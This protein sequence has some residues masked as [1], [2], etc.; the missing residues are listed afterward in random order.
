MKKFT[1][2]FLALILC[3]G[4]ATTAFAAEEETPFELT[5]TDGIDTTVWAENETLEYC[6]TDNGLD[7]DNLPYIVDTYTGVNHTPV[8]QFFTVTNTHQNNENDVEWGEAGANKGY[9]YFKKF[10]LQP[11]G[12]MKNVEVTIEDYGWTVEEQDVG[13]KYCDD[14]KV[15]YLCNTDNGTGI[16]DGY[17]HYWNAYAADARQSYHNNNSIVCLNTAESVTSALPAGEEGVF[18]LL[19]TEMVY[20]AYEYSEWL[21]YAFVEDPTVPT[22]TTSPDTYTVQKG[23]LYGKIAVDNYGSYAA[24]RALY[25]ANGYKKLVA[26]DTLTLPEKLGKYTRIPRPV[27]NAGETLYT[28]KRGDTLGAIAKTV[29]GDISKYK[30]IFERNTDRLKSA[31]TIFEGQ[32]IVLPA[33]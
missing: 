9:I 17:G 12:T 6:Y 21:T 14:G 24:W 32:T 26:G 10:T 19:Y 1:C 3:M 2:L 16:P 20:E 5:I 25:K 18:Y 8:G 29:Y 15:Y 30:A 28:V 4:L 23:D 11:A 7:G 33:K 27:A 31:N 13:G 22:T